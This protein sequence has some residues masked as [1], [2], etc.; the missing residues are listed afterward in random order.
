[1]ENLKV[2]VR[3]E[4]LFDIKNPSIIMCDSDLELALDMKDL[5]V[6]E[7]RNQ[8]L[9]QLTLVKQQNWHDSFNTYR[10]ED[11]S[12]SSRS[13]IKTSNATLVPVKEAKVSSKKKGDTV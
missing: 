6:T 12:F 1:M 4:K 10:K 7:I 3:S 5:H 8:I 11:P 13:L 9:K 2:I